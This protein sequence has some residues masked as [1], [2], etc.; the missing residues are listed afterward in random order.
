[1]KK[2]KKGTIKKFLKYYIEENSNKKLNI[3]TIGNIIKIL[4]GELDHY[5]LYDNA[6]CMPFE[7][8]SN[9]MYVGEF[10]EKD[11]DYIS[12]AFEETKKDEYHRHYCH[13]YLFS[14]NG[15]EYFSMKEGGF[16]LSELIKDFILT[17]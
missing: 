1:M 5:C 17:N 6:G 12:I 13:Y 9:D 2:L 7:I 8:H 10:Y 14:I 4:N 16:E 3:R 11:K 15:E